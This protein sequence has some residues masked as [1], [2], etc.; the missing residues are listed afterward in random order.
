MPPVAQTWDMKISSW[1]YRFLTLLLVAPET[2]PLP[3][4]ESVVKKSTRLPPV[5]DLHF[6]RAGTASTLAKQISV[7]L[8]LFTFIPTLSTTEIRYFE[9]K[10]QRIW[11][12]TNVLSTVMVT[13]GLLEHQCAATHLK[14]SSHTGAWHSHTQRSSMEWFIKSHF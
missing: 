2:R 12:V 7:D 4:D 6:S 11:S 3:R 14:L 13:A 10:K 5:H 8:F 1:D 9:K